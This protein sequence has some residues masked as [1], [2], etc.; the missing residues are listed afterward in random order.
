LDLVEAL[1]AIA[2]T[3]GATVAQVAIAWVMARG[4]D[5]VPLVGARKRE[6][7]TESL[8]AMNYPTA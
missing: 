8:G 6:R 7:L 5:I 4:K 2:E 3:K 1:R